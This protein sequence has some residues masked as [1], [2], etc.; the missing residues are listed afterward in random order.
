MWVKI[1]GIT[2]LVDAQ[3][4]FDHGAD[5]IGLN[6]WPQSKR[7]CNPD[8]ARGIVAALPPGALVFGVFVD[9]PREEIQSLVA[10]VGLTGVQ[11]HGGEPASAAEGWSVPVIRAI[12]ASSSDVVVAALDDADGRA[13]RS[14]RAG[15]GASPSGAKEAPEAVGATDFGHYRVLVDNAAGGGSGKLVDAGVLDGISLSRAIL[16]GGL[17]PENV[18]ANVLRFRP[19]GV[20]TAGGVES[21]PGIKDAN[22]IAA[23]VREARQAG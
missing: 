10:T 5:A 14:G 2:R 19:F 23:L 21:A 13:A 9:A 6:F 15:E 16:A 11:L 1:C 22:K 3:A 4:A 12:G 17:T 8:V 20:D 18:A 7:Y